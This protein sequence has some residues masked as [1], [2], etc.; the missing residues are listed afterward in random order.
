MITAGR[1]EKN[2]T[3]K[4]QKINK[5][6][7][8]NKPHIKRHEGVQNKNMK[9]PVIV[10]L[11]HANWCGHCQ[12][13]MPEWNKMEQHIKNDPK[14]SKKCDIVKIESE[15]VNNEIP[16]YENIIKKE[17]RVDGYPTI[18][19]IEGGQLKTYGGER[20][21]EAL[22]G[23][24]AGAVNSYFGGKKNTKK[25]SRKS[26]KRSSKRSSKPCKSCNVFKFW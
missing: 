10:G 20:T 5:T 24:V 8:H 2:K 16:K 25:S 21:A 18:F 3:N 9:K 17:I 11:V 23:W 12:H 14:L 6:K 26:S 7:K 19:L 4:I 15:H 13:L 1:V 22:G